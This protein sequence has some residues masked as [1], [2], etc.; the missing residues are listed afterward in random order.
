M[1]HVNDVMQLQSGERVHAIVRTHVLFLWLKLLVA[2]VFVIIP[3]FFLF[4]LLQTG[5]IGLILFLLVTGIGLVSAI[6]SFILWDANVLVLTDHRLVYVA[7]RRLWHRSVS[8]TV[9]ATIR[10]LQWGRASALET[11]LGAGTI[12]IKTGAGSVPDVIATRLPQPEKLARAITELRDHPV[13]SKQHA[14][15]EIVDVHETKESDE[16][17]VLDERRERVHAWISEA[18]AHDLKEV[19]SLMKRV[20]P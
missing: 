11:L 2:S 7:Q 6:R 20:S 18:S 19:E 9:L 8:E 12:R 3:F 10:D 13:K 15:K 16:D 14:L 17:V 1:F 4:R 5:V